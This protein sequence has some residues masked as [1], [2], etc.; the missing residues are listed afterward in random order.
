ML[1]SSPR[2]TA[3]DL[4]LWREM[5][6]ADRLHYHT[7]NV[8]AKVA[9]SLDAVREFAGTTDAYAAVS[10][11]KDSTVLAHLVSRVN[12]EMPIRRQIPMAF[13][14]VGTADVGCAE[15]KN[16]FLARWPNVYREFV[17]DIGE[18][19]ERGTTGKRDGF[20]AAEREFGPH[21]LI[22][23][24]ADESGGRTIS[25]RRWGVSTLVSCRPLLWWTAADL[26]ACLTFFWLP[27][28]PNYA[29]L[30]GGRWRREHLRTAPVG[31]KRGDQFGRAEWERE[32]YSDVLNRVA[33]GKM[34]GG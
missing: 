27:V 19:T 1:I 2:H 7:A 5:E 12:S 24:R 8:A 17:C 33:A 34:T 25:A 10:W 32:Y 30:G 4:E 22:G 6:E 28:H 20:R 31:G 18:R 15:V 9:R 16:D 26:F 13:V 21:R 23:I 14:T 29:M 11:G 3:A